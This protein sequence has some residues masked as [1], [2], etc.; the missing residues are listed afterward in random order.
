[1]SEPV[2]KCLLATLVC[3][4]CYN[5]RAEPRKFIN[6]K[7]LFLIV[8]EA[9]KFKIKMLAEPVSLA[10]FSLPP[11]LGRRATEGHRGQNTAFMRELTS[12]LMNRS[13]C[14][15]TNP[16]QLNH[17]LQIPPLALL[18]QLHFN[19]ILQGT[20]SPS[21]MHC[22][23]RLSLCSPHDCEMWVNVGKGGNAGQGRH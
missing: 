9:G 23:P 1:M 14:N 22:K 2:V 10:S 13:P 7:N 11:R 8:L 16:V 3:F 21:A 12:E 18:W 19:I 17:L 4:C 15:D 6:N 5:R 20:N